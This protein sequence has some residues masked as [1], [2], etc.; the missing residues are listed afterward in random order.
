[1]TSKEKQT[2]TVIING[3]KY[4]RRIRG[5]AAPELPYPETSDDEFYCWVTGNTVPTILKSTPNN[6]G[7]CYTPTTEYKK[8]S[9]WLA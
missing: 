1:M 7:F 6:S 9:Q 4:Q 3:E 8:V 2:M 5:Y